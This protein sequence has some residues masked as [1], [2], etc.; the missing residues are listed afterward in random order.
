MVVPVNFD[1]LASARENGA[2]SLRGRN[3]SPRRKSRR[4]ES[5]DCEKYLAQLLPNASLAPGTC[6]PESKD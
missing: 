1:V 6:D 4:R 5:K 3:G 2:K